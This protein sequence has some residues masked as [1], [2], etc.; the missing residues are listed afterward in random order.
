MTS[1]RKQAHPQL[2]GRKTALI[3]RDETWTYAALNS[4]VNRLANGLAALGMAKGDR[5]A[6]LGR[7]CVEYVVSYFALAKLGAIM[8]PVNFWYRAGEV[9]YTL[10]Q[11]GSSWLL[12]G[13]QFSA[14]AAE[15]ADMLGRDRP[16][17]RRAVG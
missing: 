2:C 17:C 15:A 6:V 8:V 10:D 16:A 11:S 4:E 1:L 12:V 3:W 13:T 14:V 9:R 7:N 5:V